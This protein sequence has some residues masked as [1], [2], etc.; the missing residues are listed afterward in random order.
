MDSMKN[1]IQLYKNWLS[2]AKLMPKQYQ[3]DGVS[4]MLDLEINGTSLFPG[5]HGGFLCD[6]MGLGKTIQILGLIYSNLQKRS[7]IVLPNALLDQWETE[8][9]R[10]FGHKPFVYHGSKKHLP[11]FEDALIVLTTYGTLATTTVKGMEKRSKLHDYKWDRVIYDEAH[12]LRNCKTKSFRAAKHLKVDIKWFVT[13]TPTQNKIS[14][15]YSLCDIL[16]IHKDKYHGFDNLKVVADLFKI[17]RTKKDVG[18]DLSPPIVETITV[19]WQSDTEMTLAKDLHSVFQFT[20]VH[21]GNVNL[22]IMLLTH[23]NLPALLRMRQSCILPSLIKN[24]I[25]ALVNEGIIDSINHSLYGHSKMD[26]IVNHILHRK[27][28][29][30]KKIVFCHFKHEIRHIHRRLIQAGIDSDFIDGAV[31]HSKR[32]DILYRNPTVLILQIMTSNEG[33]NLQKY[34]HIYFSSPHWNPAVEDQAIARAHRIGQL[35]TV[36]VYRF[37]MAGFGHDSLSI[38]SYINSVQDKK[39]ELNKLF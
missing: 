25:D 26:A 34:N 7:L 20:N 13:G 1:S 36:F 19:D 4:K 32:R 16:G 29:S 18:I 8:I 14:D 21:F 17:A 6:E 31:S 30:D 15:I 39:R 38:D 28:D 37:V 10:L 9:I 22:L 12:H 23:S 5:I 3:I 35:K 11:G 33:L 2:M 27:H 24:K